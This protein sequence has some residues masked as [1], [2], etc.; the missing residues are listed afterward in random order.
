[1]KVV[2]PEKKTRQ[3]S[4]LVDEKAYKKLKSYAKKNNSS[5]VYVINELIKQYCI[6]EKL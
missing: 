1:M 5:A 6:E 3:I 4:L 2:F